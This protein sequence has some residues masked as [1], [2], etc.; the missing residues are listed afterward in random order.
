MSIRIRFACRI[1]P[2]KSI[3]IQ[4]LWV[5]KI[6]IRYRHRCCA[7]IGAHPPS[8]AIRVI[9]CSEIVESGFKVVL[10]ACKFI[11][12]RV[13]VDELKLA[14][15]GVI[16][17]LGLDHPGG[18]GDH[19]R[20]PQ[21]VRKVIEHAARAGRAVAAGYTL[22]IKENVFRFGRAGQV[23]FSHHAVISQ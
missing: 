6:R 8:Q 10:L 12:V 15:P 19:R 11:V 4:R 14:A 3:Q 21:M 13:V 2:D 7:P 16:I 20:G 1:T 9:P 22:A 5:T 18:I 17:R 23:G